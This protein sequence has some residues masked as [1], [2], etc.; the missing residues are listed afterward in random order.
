[1]SRAHSLCGVSPGFFNASEDE[2]D[3]YASL[4]CHSV[5]A[6]EW[7]RARRK[8]VTSC[9]IVVLVTRFQA[10]EKTNKKATQWVAYA[11]CGLARP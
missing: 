8:S 11:L 6:L 3:D 9:L 1:M 5:G 4:I 10:Q 2:D 7:R